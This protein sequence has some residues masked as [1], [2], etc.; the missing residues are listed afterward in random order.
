MTELEILDIIPLEKYPVDTPDFFSY[1]GNAPLYSV[2]K[3]PLKNKVKTGFVIN[4]KNLKQSKLLV[5]K[6][7]YGFKPI[8][9][10]IYSHPLISE[11]QIKFGYWLKN[12][13]NI[14]LPHA[15]YLLLRWHKKCASVHFQIK[16]VK[17]K[18]KNDNLKLK[19]NGIIFEKLHD[20]LLKDLPTLIIVPQEEYINYIKSLIPNFLISKTIIADLSLP[21]EKFQ[22][23]LKKIYGN[24]KILFVGT[25]NSIF[26]PWQNLKKIIIYEDESIFYKENFR[27]PYFNYLNLIEKFSEIAKIPLCKISSFPSLISPITQKINPPKFYFEAIG[28]N[29]F[30]KIEEIVKQYKKIIIFSPQKIT[31][32]KIICEKCRNELSCPKCDLPLVLSDDKIFCKSCFYKEILPKECGICKSEAFQIKGVGA[33][34]TARYLKK[35]GINVIFIKNHKDIERARKKK[36]AY[37]LIGSQ[38]LLTPNLPNAD[39]FLF[40]DFDRAFRSYDI[41]LKEKFLRILEFLSRCSKKIILQTDLDKET[42]Q[43]ITTNEIFKDILKE[44]E[45]QFLPPYSR[46]IKLISK[47]SDLQK[48]NKRMVEIRKEIEKRKTDFKERVEIWGPFLKKIPKKLSRYQLELV[49]RIDPNL[50]LKKFLEGIRVNEIEV[51]GYSMD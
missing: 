37:I 45:H 26:L 2:V 35:Q 16:N 47:L 30:E 40:L 46:L 12:F 38:N 8:K 34:W 25:K 3:I 19:S 24:E 39:L 14:S 20:D 43:K 5:K 31:A 42:L 36:T 6:A 51:D 13:A 28:N 9:E 11:N 23:L 18:T 7:E 48:L 21:S 22:E 29:D 4:K 50:N 1:F 44:R 33:E 32:V 41:F 10:I 15:F 49:L 17:I 27:Q